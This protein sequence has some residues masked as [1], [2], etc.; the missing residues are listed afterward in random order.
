MRAGLGVT[1]VNPNGSMDYA[2][3]QKWVAALNAYNNGAGYLGHNDW[4]FPVAPLV[5]RTCANTGPGGGSFGP[6]CSGSGLS[7]L[8][9]AG[10]KLTFPSSA[11]PGFGA[12]VSPLH[13]LKSSYYWALQNDGGAS[14]GGQEVFSFARASRAASRHKI[15]TSTRSP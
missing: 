15:T 1:G 14:N 3:A 9:S 11:V 2:T 4:Q 12:T 5:D 13:N 10:L 6:L 7:N 8:Y